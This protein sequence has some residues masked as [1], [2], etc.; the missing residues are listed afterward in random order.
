M[1]VIKTSGKGIETVIATVQDFN[2]AGKAVAN[3]Y[4]GKRVPTTDTWEIRMETA[5][6]QMCN[7]EYWYGR[8]NTTYHTR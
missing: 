3:D 7:G 2:E 5:R 4:Y 1:Q 6:D 8:G